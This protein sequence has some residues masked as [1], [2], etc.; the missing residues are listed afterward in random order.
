MKPT[1]IDTSFLIALV[2]ADDAMHERAVA[3]QK[4]L[5]GPFLTTEYI[6]LEFCDALTSEALRGL[7]IE[8]LAML[9][10]DRDINIIPASTKLLDEG[11]ALFKNRADKTWGLTDCIS[12]LV[13]KNFDS[14]DALTADRHFEQAGFNALLKQ[15]PPK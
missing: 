11:L 13:M 12:F 15:L 6:L 3:W 4:S 8:T 7:A 2:L 5:A 1:F 10:G 9:R 14:N